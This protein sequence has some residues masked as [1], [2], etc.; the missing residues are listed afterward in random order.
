MSERSRRLDPRV[1][2]WFIPAIACVALG[3]VRP[4]AIATLALL[5]ALGSLRGERLRLGLPEAI[6]LGVLAFQLLQLLLLPLSVLSLIDP[7][8]ATLVQESWAAAGRTVTT[9]PLSLAP[10]ET[11]FASSQLALFLLALLITRRETLHNRADLLIQG[12]IVAAAGVVAV[13]LL[14][15]VTGLDAIYGVVP[16]RG[17]GISVVTGPFVSS[18]HLAVFCAATLP[19]VIDRTLTVEGWLG[20]I[21]G[22]VLSAALAVIALAT[23][24]RTAFL[25]LGAGLGVL[26]AVLVVTRRVKARAALVAVVAGVG[27]V[28]AAM[29]ATAGRVKAVADLRFLG[30]ASA[31]L[32][33]WAL[34][35]DVTRDHWLGGVGAGA[36]HSLWW[37]VRPGPSETT[38]Q[39]A[40]S[41]YV[42]TLVSLGIPATA[43]VAIG[44]LLCLFAVTRTAR[45]RARAGTPG[46]AG[47]FAGLVALAATS[48][49][50]L[51]TSQPGIALLA[52][53]L[54][55]TFA[56][57]ERAGA[58]LP[59]WAPSALAAIVLL[60][61]LW[62]S[63]RT[64]R[65]TDAIFAT[66]ADDPIAVALRHPADPYGFGWAATKVPERGPELL[67]RALV[68]DPHGA[69]PHRIAVNVLLRA[70]LQSQARIEARLALAGATTRELPRFVTDALAVWPAEADRLALLPSDPDRARRVAE[71]MTVRDP[72]LG[73]AAWLS[74]A[75]R[76]E[77]VEGALARGL[78]FFGAD[79]KESALALA[80]S[81][82]IDSP[83][84]V[85][86][87]L[88]HA[89]L[90]L[91]N[92]R[93][94]D[95]AGHLAR[96]AE[97]AD[98]T[99][100]QRAEVT[101]QRGRMHQADPEKLRLL[102]EEPAGSTVPER[103][104]RAWIQGRV[105]E[106][107]G[108][109][110]QALRSYSEAARLRPDVPWFRQ[111]VLRYRE[112]AV[113]PR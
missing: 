49:V 70:G 100:R 41:V 23:L 68:L 74:L 58:R 43:L 36:F 83:D 46:A 72:A 78:M 85:A 57:R 38:A 77:P 25:G 47:A 22:A 102:L 35:S 24:S 111:E 44:V 28:A 32:D 54:L 37:T 75:Q 59:R 95:A 69:E 6:V 97:R 55:G 29:V 26:V 79:E 103:A 92:G 88:Q 53:W 8:T 10:G 90:L 89:R 113:A 2:P 19:I 84:D 82:L 104:V 71:E 7:N 13:V 101:W 50:T 52:A 93:E 60:L 21:N 11:A 63:P 110:S 16:A 1:G 81:G 105:H 34:A 98:L 5:L 94:G 48:A 33:L 17:R 4:A 86:L 108:A 65:G 112:A 62:G 91:A 80:E 66:E 61:V 107:D 18:N 30:D 109:R 99:P 45:R 51:A 39:D 42:Q 9:H 15:A 64:L 96:I 14:H 12:V 76:P 31:R 3:G 106:A 73:R 20:R 40:E 27:C 67:N 87:L 56:D